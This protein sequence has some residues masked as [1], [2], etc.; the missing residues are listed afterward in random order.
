MYI[1][2]RFK[3]GN[4]GCNYIPHIKWIALIKKVRYLKYKKR[5]DCE[6]RADNRLFTRQ[7]E[8]WLE[9]FTRLQKSSNFKVNIPSS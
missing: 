6:G 4:P 7:K 9:L 1:S 3:D 2:N 8:V 5:M